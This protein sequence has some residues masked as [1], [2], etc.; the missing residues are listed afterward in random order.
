M[1]KLKIL[2]FICLFFTACKKERTDYT[3]IP[4]VPVE[5]VLYTTQPSFFPVGVVGGWMYVN[6]GSRG[7]ILY[8]YSI[9]EFRA[10]ER[11]TP[12]KADKTCARAIVDSVNVVAVEL[13]DSSKYVLTTGAVLEG[14]AVLSLKQY[15][16]SF[17]GNTLRIYN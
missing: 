13:C 14:P 5:I 3:L 15:N 16:T 2:L 9:D 1:A 10:Y 4:D 8:R 17:D 7:I 11:H 12:Y 6:G